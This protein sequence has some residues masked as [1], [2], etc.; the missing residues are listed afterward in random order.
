MS[1]I[2]SFGI[3]QLFIHRAVR[4]WSDHSEQV[5]V[6]AVQTVLDAAGFDAT[7]T[8]APL[9]GSVW[10]QPCAGPEGD[11]ATVWLKGLTD[12][13]YPHL[14]STDFSAQI[15]LV[16]DALDERISKIHP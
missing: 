5:R 6:A 10:P 11:E 14:G 1:T 8:C 7:A 2:D 9:N 4:R 16:Q 12:A 3:A 13:L 15:K